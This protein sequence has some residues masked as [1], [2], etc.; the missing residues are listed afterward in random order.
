MDLATTRFALK[1]NLVAFHAILEG[2]AGALNFDQLVAGIED[3]LDDN[4]TCHLG[5]G[6]GVTKMGLK[7]TSWLQIARFDF[8]LRANAQELA[9][10]HALNRAPTPR[11]KKPLSQKKSDF[12]KN[13]MFQ[14]SYIRC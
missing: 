8:N 2:W 13:A 11:E 1:H 7:W 5:G 9:D 12:E 14:R 6:I 10:S 4:E 3:S